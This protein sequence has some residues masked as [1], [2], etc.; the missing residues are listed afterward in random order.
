VRPGGEYCGMMDMT[1]TSRGEAASLAERNALTITI[2]AE[3]SE[4]CATM[5]TGDSLRAVQQLG[6]VILPG[7]EACEQQQCV[8][9][10]VHCRQIPNGASN[11]PINTMATVA[12]WKNPLRMRAVYHGSRSIV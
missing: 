4:D 10:C 8:V 1:E 7:C 11:V 12:R 6:R 2:G 5:A 9:R 3:P